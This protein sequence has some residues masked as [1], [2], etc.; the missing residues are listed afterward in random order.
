M[1]DGKFTDYGLVLDAGED[2]VKLRYMANDD[3]GS[4][5]FRYEQGVETPGVDGKDDQVMMDVGIQITNEETCGWLYQ[6]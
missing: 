5:K 6:S 2:N 3:K 1:M 4:R